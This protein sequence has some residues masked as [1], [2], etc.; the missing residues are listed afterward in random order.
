MTKSAAFLL[1]VVLL[2][3]ACFAQGD[4]VPAYNNGP[5]KPGDALPILPK[6]QLWGESFKYPYQ[7]RAYE[8]AAKIPD[9]INQCRVTAIVSVKGTTVST[10]A[11]RARTV[12]IARCA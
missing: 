8:L 6:D 9:V 7:V 2:A 12:R 10:V 4:H 1:V 5:L 11:S 3:V